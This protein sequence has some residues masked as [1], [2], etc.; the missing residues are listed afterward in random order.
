ML[1]FIKMCHKHRRQP[2]SWF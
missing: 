2:R 1:Q